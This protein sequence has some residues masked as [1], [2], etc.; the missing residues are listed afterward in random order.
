MPGRALSR[1]GGNN[2]CEGLE[3][4]DTHVY[5]LPKNVEQF[6]KMDV[7]S[8]TDEYLQKFRYSCLRPPEERG[9]IYED[10]CLIFNRWQA[11][12]TTFLVLV[13]TPEDKLTPIYTEYLQ[14]LKYSCLR[15]SE[16]RGAIYE[17]GCLMFNRWQAW[18]T[19]FLIL[20]TTLEDKLTPIYIEY[21]QKLRYSCLRPPEE[22]GAISEDGKSLWHPRLPERAVTG[23]STVISPLC[24]IQTVRAANFKIFTQTTHI[25][26]DLDVMKMRK[27]VSM[28]LSTKTAPLMMA[29]SRSR[30]GPTNYKQETT[31]HGRL[32]RPESFRSAE[33]SGV[34]RVVSNGGSKVSIFRESLQHAFACRIC[35]RSADGVPT[36]NVHATFPEDASNMGSETLEHIAV[37]SGRLSTSFLV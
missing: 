33:S 28:V 25:S 27:F 2:A 24:T 8:T 35:C 11:W 31:D 15:P 14:K 3:S 30:F 13:T 29:I 17:D 32:P 21:L 7:K 22:R 36:D 18:I 12:I 34:D 26:R 9:A 19:T 37:Y 16:E 23:L 5:G 6:M 4:L 20:V 10:G 1:R